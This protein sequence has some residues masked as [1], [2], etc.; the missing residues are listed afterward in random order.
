ME[1]ARLLLERG[2]QANM[3]NKVGYS[4]NITMSFGGMFLWYMW[5]MC[6]MCGWCVVY[7]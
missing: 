3:A 5:A 7:V 6:V 1:I 4:Y 2:A